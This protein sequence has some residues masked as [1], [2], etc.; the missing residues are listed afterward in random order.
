MDS[1]AIPTVSFG[2]VDSSDFGFGDFAP[3]TDSV[4]PEGPPPDEQRYYVREQDKRPT[5]TG[6]APPDPAP[7]TE[8]MPLAP[9]SGRAAALS[10]LWAAA[11]TAA[12]AWLGGACGAG[13]GLLVAGALRNVARARAL[14]GSA[15]AQSRTEATSSATWSLIGLCGGGY[16]GY[17]AYEQ[18]KSED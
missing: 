15:D 16:L 2:A 6:A 12:G 4:G 11:G 7:Q 14:W 18:Q 9:A 13:A 10:V 1:R 17:R 5:S 3:F 8:T